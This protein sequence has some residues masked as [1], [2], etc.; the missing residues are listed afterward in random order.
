MKMLSLLAGF[1]SLFFSQMSHANSSFE[2]A[3]WVVNSPVVSVLSLNKDGT[4]LDT[5]CESEKYFSEQVCDKESSSL[6]AFTRNNNGLCNLKTEKLPS[7]WY[8]MYQ[9]TNDKNTLYIK[10]DPN[11]KR[12]GLGY[13]LTAKRLVLGVWPMK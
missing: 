9:P 5:L 10:A 3:W 4:V 8:H 6:Y 13:V 7:C 1:A 12:P 11:N 2:G